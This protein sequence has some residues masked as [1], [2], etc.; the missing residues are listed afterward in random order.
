MTD[1][2]GIMDKDRAL[3][4]GQFGRLVS[5]KDLPPDGVFIAYIQEAMK[6]NDEGIKRPRNKKIGVSDFLF[7][8][9]EKAPE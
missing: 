2:E 1:P 6:L 8:I 3:A 5:V 7:P 9:L 4:M